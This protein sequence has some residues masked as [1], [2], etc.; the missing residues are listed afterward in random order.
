MNFN[1]VKTTAVVGA[2]GKGH[3]IA[4]TLGLAGYEVRLNS[5]NDASLQ[6]SMDFIKADLDRLVRLDMTKPE[7]AW[8]TFPPP[9]PWMKRH[10]TAMW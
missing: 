5:T 1:E 7:A 2:E 9:R 4:F 8:P 6:K 3:G 10:E